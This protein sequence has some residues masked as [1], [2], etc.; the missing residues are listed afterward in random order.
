MA[1]N[2]KVVKENKPKGHGPGSKTF[3]TDAG[4]VANKVPKS[5]WTKTAK[6]SP[7]KK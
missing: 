2:K 7:N 5:W 1:D 6:A 3:G 4:K